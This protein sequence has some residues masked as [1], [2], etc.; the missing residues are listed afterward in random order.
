MKRDSRIGF[1]FGAV[2]EWGIDLAGLETDL[3]WLKLIGTIRV[4]EAQKNRE[5]HLPPG[6]FAEQIT[7]YCWLLAAALPTPT[8]LL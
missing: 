1:K 2:P 3:L 4:S 5:A 8:T 7:L 6:S